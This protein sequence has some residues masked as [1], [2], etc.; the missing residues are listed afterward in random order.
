MSQDEASLMTNAAVRN[1]QP[2]SEDYM[3]ADGI[4]LSLFVVSTQVR[5]GQLRA[6]SQ[7]ALRSSSQSGVR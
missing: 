1:A 5:L 2:W 6:Q 4:G 3:L 7:A